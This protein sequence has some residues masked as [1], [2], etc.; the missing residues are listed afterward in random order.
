MHFQVPAH[1]F[2]TKCTLKGNSMDYRW[3][4]W[5]LHTPN[6]ISH[7]SRWWNR[8]NWHQR[9]LMKNTLGWAVLA[10]FNLHLFC[11]LSFFFGT[12]WALNCVPSHFTKQTWSIS[13]SS[14]RHFAV[15]KEITVHKI[16][17]KHYIWIY[18]QKSF[19]NIGVNLFIHCS[20]IKVVKGIALQFNGR[21]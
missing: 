11:F 13:K 5:N 20:T 14:W 6:E 8:S 19:V 2:T 18:L 3:Y 4:D 16:E 7:I 15:A 12:W 21:K 10:S 9:Y 17:N 1:S